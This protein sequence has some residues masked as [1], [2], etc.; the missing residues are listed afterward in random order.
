MGPEGT[1]LAFKSST[2]SA[3]VFR[4]V[5]FSSSAFKAFRFFERSGAI[6]KRG[7]SS[8]G[9]V[10]RASQSRR[11]I[12]WPE[13]AILMWPSEVLNTPVGIEVG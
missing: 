13:A 5:A 8:S 4:A 3:L 7:S 9:S 1:P 2:H 6:L 11:N 10:P 12:C